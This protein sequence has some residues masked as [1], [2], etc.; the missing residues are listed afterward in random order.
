MKQQVEHLCI[1]HWSY[2]VLPLNQHRVVQYSFFAFSLHQHQT[3]NWLAS[4]IWFRLTDL[5]RLT[6]LQRKWNKSYFYK[7]FWKYIKVSSKFYLQSGIPCFL[8]HRNMVIIKGATIYA[9]GLFLPVHF[10]NIWVMINKFRHV[11]CL[12]P[13]KRT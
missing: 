1:P 5:K 11:P 6:D 12:K 3:A 9:H 2:V 8:R 7:C 4:V 10:C 13:H